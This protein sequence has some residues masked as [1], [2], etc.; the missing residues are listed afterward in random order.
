MISIHTFELRMYLKNK[1]F[2]KIKKKLCISNSRQSWTE[3]SYSDKGL[4]IILY[5]G[6]EKGFIYLKYIVNLKRTLDKDDYL[7][8]LEPTPEN[9]THVWETIRT[10]WEEIGCGIPFDRF[11]LSRLDF[12][13]DIKMGNTEQVQEYIRLLNKSILRSSRERFSVE[14]IYHSQQI[15]E[16][17]KKELQ[18]NCCKYKITECENLQF[19]NKIYELENENLPIPL[20]DKESNFQILRIELQMHKTKRISTLLENVG[21]YDKP[22]EEQFLF[23]IA[24]APVILIER[25]EKL[26]PHGNYY[27]KSHVV[28]HVKNDAFIKNKT[29]K[30]I[31]QL[32]DDC[33]RNTNLGRLLELDKQSG[34][35]NKRKKSLK[36]LSAHTI[37]PVTINSQLYEYEM[38]PDIFHLIT[39][40]IRS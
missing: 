18:Q 35:A 9:I 31:L 3:H 22:I 30:K 2:A 15:T 29:K 8:L 7:H 40:E 27:Q 12:T 33:N 23:F 32:L 10:T 16:N 38:L 19:Y 21:L 20:K 17:A 5:K 1:E 25:L 4:Q 13:C 6:K 39:G 14:G 28:Q 37:N 26:Y 34:E 11:Y 24:H 36:Y